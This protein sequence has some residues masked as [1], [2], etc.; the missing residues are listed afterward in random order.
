M[1]TS[2]SDIKDTLIDNTMFQRT[3]AD[4]T[5]TQYLDMAIRGCKR[6][7][8]DTG[9]E[10]N[11]DTE[12]TSGDSPTLSRTLTILEQE[13]C[14][15]AAEIE[16]FKIVSYYWNTLVGYTT[17]ALSITNADKP[18]SFMK[19]IIKEKETYLVELFHKMTEI[20][21]A[22]EVTDITVDAVDFDFD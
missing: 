9:I 21:N 7:Y 10:S 20:S 22:S 11:W 1:S 17:N 6:F 3:P 15:V 18:F 19:S 5:D 14:L 4:L 13:Y 16:Y 2:I 8:I 12:Y